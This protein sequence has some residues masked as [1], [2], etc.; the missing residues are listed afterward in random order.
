MRRFKVSRDGT[1]RL[2]SETRSCRTTKANQEPDDVSLVEPFYVPVNARFKR[3]PKNFWDDEK[4]AEQHLTQKRALST[5]DK[6][7]MNSDEADKAKARLNKTEL[8][9]DEFNGKR[10]VRIIRSSR[11][12]RR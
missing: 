3:D 2:I 6:K 11:S 12:R 10:I 1:R 9:D 7:P 4:P 5:L 8:V